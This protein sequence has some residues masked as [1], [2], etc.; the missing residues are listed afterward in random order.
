MPTCKTCNTPNL[1]WKRSR[2]GNWVL[3]TN[4]TTPHFTECADIVKAAAELAAFQAKAQAGRAE[5]KAWEVCAECGLPLA[6]DRLESGFCPG[7]ES[8][9]DD[10][11]EQM[12]SSIFVGANAVSAMVRNGDHDKSEALISDFKTSITDSLNNLLTQTAIKMPPNRPNH[13][14]ITAPQ[15]TAFKVDIKPGQ[16]VMDALTQN[17]VTV[18]PIPKRATVTPTPAP[19]PVNGEPR[20][21]PCTTCNIPNRL[22][23]GELIRGVACHHCT[24]K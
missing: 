22:T 9:L 24:N 12:N 11:N 10:I 17:P 7:C 4:D 19:T 15:D 14:T 23:Y 21:I 5:L 16:S 2:A 13:Q 20:N 18:T 6:K 3:W 1:T 8:I